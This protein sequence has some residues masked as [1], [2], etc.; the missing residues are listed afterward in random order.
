M[1]RRLRT[2]IKLFLSRNILFIIG[3]L[4]ICLL[5][6]VS[7]GDSQEI[8]GLTPKPEKPQIITIAPTKN[9]KLTQAI[10]ILPFVDNKVPQDWLYANPVTK[11]LGKKVVAALEDDLTDK[12]ILKQFKLLAK[13]NLLKE[14]WPDF[15]NAI[16]LKALGN[17]QPEVRSVFYTVL[18]FNQ[19]RLL[20]VCHGVAGLNVSADMWIA[21]TPVKHGALIRVRKGLYPIVVEAYHG[22]RTQWLE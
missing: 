21:G 19:D 3:F 1:N 22:K 11:G 4:T 6:F 16:D 10:P 7:A 17:N 15:T 9:L 20:R 5:S 8:Q 18:T 13:D 14:S 12:S 2:G